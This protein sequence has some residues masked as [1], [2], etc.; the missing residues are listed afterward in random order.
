MNDDNGAEEFLQWLE[1]GTKVFA[2]FREK[3][4]YDPVFREEMRIHPKIFDYLRQCKV[5][6]EQAL[7]KAPTSF[8]YGVQQPL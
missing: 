4:L 7:D 3:Y 8:S 1:I 2:A 6:I 5:D